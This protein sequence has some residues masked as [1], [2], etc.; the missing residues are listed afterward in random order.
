MIFKTLTEMLAYQAE[1]CPDALFT[2]FLERG[3]VAGTY[4]YAQ[5]WNWA[6]RWATLFIE[7]GLRRGDGFAR[8]PGRAGRG[9]A[10][11]RRTG[12]DA[13]PRR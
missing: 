10:R 4:T 13:G 2:R 8:A 11:V 12:A 6:A 7:R 5:T 1:A 9:P 3:E